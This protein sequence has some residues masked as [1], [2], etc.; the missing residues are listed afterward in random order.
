MPARRRHFVPHDRS[1]VPPHAHPRCRFFVV[2]VLVVIGGNRQFDPFPGE[3]D[4]PLFD[5][6]VTMSRMS[7]RVNVSV[8]RDVALRWNFAPNGDGLRQ[9][10][11]RCDSHL[12]PS[13]RVLEAASGED[14][15]PARRDTQRRASGRGEDHPRPHGQMIVGLGPERLHR[16]PLVQHRDATRQRMLCVPI[17]HNHIERRFAE[18]LAHRTV[19]N[20]DLTHANVIRRRLASRRR[21]DVQQIISVHQAAR[22]DGERHDHVVLVD[23]QCAQPLAVE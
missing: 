7:Q 13:E 15:V 22:R 21:F 2:D 9:R 18:C 8:A 20:L 14:R 4:H 3:R 16:A 5:R 19:C 1:E 10:L 12:S 6:R 17:E 11:S 23:G